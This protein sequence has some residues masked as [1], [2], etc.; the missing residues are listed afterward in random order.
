LSRPG[1]F[2]YGRFDNGARALAEVMEVETGDRV[3]DI[4]CGVGTNG[5]FAALRAGP[6]GFIAFVDSN[7]RAAALAEVNAKAN[8][9]ANFKVVASSTIDGL[10]EGNFD[11]ALANPPYFANASIARL[12]IERARALLTPQGRL[13]LVT[14][15]PDQV[16]P[17]LEEFF[18]GQIE[19][20]V[21]RGYA[22]LCA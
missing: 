9:V 14:K 5:V 19:M 8:G 22:V 7:A 18:E 16:T 10:E 20:A 4:G 3:L 17:L 11:V 2:S 6:E 12:F 1:T 21:N 15:Q 13:F